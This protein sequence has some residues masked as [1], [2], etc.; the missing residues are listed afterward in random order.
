MTGCNVRCVE[1]KSAGSR[2]KLAGVQTAMATHREAANAESTIVYVIH[3][4]EI[5]IDRYQR[6]NSE[7]FAVSFTFKSRPHVFASVLDSIRNSND[8]ERLANCRFNKNFKFIWNF[9]SKNN[10]R[11]NFSNCKSQAQCQ[12]AKKNNRRNG[13]TDDFASNNLGHYEKYN[14]LQYLSTY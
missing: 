5:A 6:P 7:H 12:T 3:N 10:L 1:R 9:E 2:N 13:R 11:E 4:A 14:P 8:H